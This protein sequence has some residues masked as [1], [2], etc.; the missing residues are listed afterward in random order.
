[1]PLYEYECLEC[2]SRFEKLV[3]T[4]AETSQ[5]KC[6]E[7]QSGDLEEMFSSFSSAGRSG[8]SGAGNCAP[9]GG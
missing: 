9:G 3:R 7:C 2:G 6:P 4:A 1:M 5:L 8:D